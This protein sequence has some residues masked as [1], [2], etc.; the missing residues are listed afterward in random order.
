MGRHS[1]GGSG[2]RRIHGSYVVTTTCLIPFLSH[3]LA[4]LVRTEL[5]GIWGNSIILKAMDVF[6]SER[7]SQQWEHSSVTELTDRAQRDTQGEELASKV[8][9]I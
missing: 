8:H 4:H 7:H 9:S 2:A 1:G 6:G 3:A 5:I